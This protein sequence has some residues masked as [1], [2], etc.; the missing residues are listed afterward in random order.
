ML[1]EAPKYIKLGI[2]D[3]IS[4]MS[5]KKYQYQ[6]Q[7]LAT[8]SGLTGLKHSDNTNTLE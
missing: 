6:Y 1:V 3:F 8:I 2:F 7:Y 5:L 4:T